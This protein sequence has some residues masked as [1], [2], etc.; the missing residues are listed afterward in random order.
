MQ[1]ILDKTLKF[2][3]EYDKMKDDLVTF[4]EQEDKNDRNTSAHQRLS[5]AY[6][7]SATR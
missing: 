1:K 4:E 2:S 6:Y 5:S 7:T 3:N